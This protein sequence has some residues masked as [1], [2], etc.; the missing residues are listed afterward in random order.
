MDQSQLEI[1]S[2]KELQVLPYLT[3]ESPSHLSRTW[4]S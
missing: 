1:L 2:Y 4:P 3:L